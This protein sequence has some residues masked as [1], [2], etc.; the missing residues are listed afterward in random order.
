MNELA[1]VI[2]SDTDGGI[3]SRKFLFAVGTS[4]A[5]FLGAGIAAHWVSFGTNYETLIGGLLGCLGLYLTGNVTNTW[6]KGKHLKAILDAQGVEQ[7]TEP[8]EGPPV[9]K[10]AP[11]VNQ[12][13][14][15]GP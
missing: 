6:A 15:E 3:T 2:L 13:E 11:K 8:P 1:K 7:G 14:A 9:A 4:V 12:E 5:I 10:R